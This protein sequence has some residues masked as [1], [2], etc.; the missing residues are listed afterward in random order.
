MSFDVDQEQERLSTV[1]LDKAAPAADTSSVKQTVIK[2]PEGE[3]SG[4]TD[5]AIPDVQEEKPQVTEDLDQLAD[6][7]FC[8]LYYLPMISHK[9]NIGQF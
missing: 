4:G 6:G 8:V 1:Q 2:Q 3:E 9:A 7:G 5:Q